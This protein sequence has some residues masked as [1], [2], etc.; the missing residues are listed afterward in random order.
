MT[1]TARIS[2]LEPPYTPEVETTLRKWMPP[3]AGVPP[4]ALFR[5]LARHRM[6]FERMRPLGAGLL[7]H[8]ML[9]ARARELLV[10]RTC[11]RCGAGYEWGVHVAAFAAAA[12]LGDDDTRATALTTPQEVA[13]REDDDA[14]AMRVADELH[15]ASTLSDA[16]FALLAER[17]GEAAIL[18]MVAVVGFYHLVSYVVRAAGVELEPWAAPYPT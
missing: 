5:T 11:A 9:P 16:S 17:F 7:G 13:E 10:L 15:D 1:S 12:G 6:L 14:L 18:E 2:P 8:G 4:L 3:G